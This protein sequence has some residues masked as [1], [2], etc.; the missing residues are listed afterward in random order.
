MKFDT[1]LHWN[2][3]HENH[4]VN[5]STSSYAIEKEKSFQRNSI[6]CDLGGGDGTDSLYFIRNGHTVYLYDISDSALIRANTKVK[7]A[8]L[9]NKLTTSQIDLTKDN[10]PSKSD[11]FDILYSRLSIH[12]FTKERTIE[13]L[14]EIYRILKINGVAYIVVKSPEDVREMD[15]LRSNS[16][17]ISEGVFIDD[18]GMIK[19]RFTKEQYKEM[20]KK[21]GI[22][23]YE[24][25][26]YTEHFGEQK[27]YIHSKADNLLYLE[28]II[29]KS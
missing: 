14:K 21:A 3:S 15:Y 19:T 13:I 4:P 1:K 20:L 5:R 7:K 16:K 25:K 2:K 29:R 28:L 9:E 26:D 8:N 17:V 23:N 12:Y 27:I 11:F 24:I 6:V 22:T 10:I 18:D